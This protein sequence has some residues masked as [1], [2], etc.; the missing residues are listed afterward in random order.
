MGINFSFELI[1]RGY[2]PKGGGEIKLQV[3]PSTVKSILFLKRKTKKKKINL[4]IF[5]IYK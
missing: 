4:F 5:K 1:K 2:Y 3:T